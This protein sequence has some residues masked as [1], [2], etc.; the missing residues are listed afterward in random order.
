MTTM[1][2][3][4]RQLVMIRAELNATQEELA[5]EARLSPSTISKI[6]LGFPI[7][8]RTAYQVLYAINRLRTRQGLADLDFHEIEWNL[9]G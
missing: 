9:S 1:M 3:T 5:T 8:K 7:R 4:Q 2:T 6:E